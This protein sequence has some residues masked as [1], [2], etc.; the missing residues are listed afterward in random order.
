MVFPKCRTAILGGVGSPLELGYWA[1]S[2][3]QQASRYTSG[4][5]TLTGYG[6]RTSAKYS[7]HLS[8]FRT[9]LLNL[10]HVGL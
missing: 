2:D 8:E 7:L 9:D 4:I 1:H 6:P 10:A 5:F 3:L